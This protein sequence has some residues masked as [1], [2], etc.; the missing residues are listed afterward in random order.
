MP[1]PM[2]PGVTP[3]QRARAPS[4][5]KTDRKIDNWFLY[6]GRLAYQKTGS[7]KV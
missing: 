4:F 7:K 1:A 3:L 6:V 5:L 2:N